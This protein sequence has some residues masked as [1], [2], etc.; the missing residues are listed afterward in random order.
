MEFLFDTANLEMIEKYAEIFP[1]TGVTSN[2]TIVKAEGSIEFFAHFRRVRKLIGENRTLHIQV[3]AQDC[4]TILKEAD[5][6]LS[7]I[8]SNVYIKIPTTE[9][10]LKAMQRLKSQGVGITA[11]AIYSKIQGFLAIAAGADYIAPYC[12][13]MENMDIDAF[14]TIASLAQMIA[15][16]DVPAKIVAASFKNIAQVNR[17]FESGAHTVTVNP[18][19]LHE[20][21]G[22]AAIGKAVDQFSSDWDALYHGKDILDMATHDQIG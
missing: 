16:Q 3:L 4:E 15:E 2:P 12:N 22:M 9:Q 10:G 20:A 17:A 14:D 6:I 13:R 18:S 19:L 11:T 5:A 1:Y 7:H 21:F 8:D